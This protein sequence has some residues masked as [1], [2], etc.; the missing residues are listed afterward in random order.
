M[1]GR[2]KRDDKIFS[3]CGH[4]VYEGRILGNYLLHG[5]INEDLES[6]HICYI[7]GRRTNNNID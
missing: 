5:M 1:K 7:L 2:R 3:I 4:E 6:F